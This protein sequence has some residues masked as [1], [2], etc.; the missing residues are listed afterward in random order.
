MNKL[1][2]FNF[3]LKPFIIILIIS[4]LYLNGSYKAVILILILFL[5]DC[6][7][8]LSKYWDKD[9]DENH[10]TNSINKCI[11]EELYNLI[12]PTV[13]IKKDGEI[14]WCN[15]RF[16]SITKDEDLIKRN[17]MSVI[18]GINIDSIINSEKIYVHQKL[19]LGKRV[20]DVQGMKVL[21]NEDEYIILFFNDISDLLTSDGIR[22]EVVLIEVD[23]FTDVLEATDE[24]DRPLVVAEIERTINAYAHN[25]NAM[26]RKYDNNKYVLSVQN[27][28]IAEQEREKFPIL[29]E[30]S[31]IKKGNK[32]E[33]TIS[34]GIGRDGL[35]PLENNNFANMALELA[36]GR[37]GDQVV[38]KNNEKIKF[39]GGNS[40]E[41]EKRTR[42]RA[43]VV[44]NALNELI[45]DSSKVY[46]MGHTN[47]DM[48]CFGSALALSS[49]IR[50]MGKKSY[51]LLGSD[52]NPIEY[53]FDRLSEDSYYND[54][55]ISLDKA[56]D[57]LDDETLV[58]VVDVH[59]RGY[60]EDLGLIERAKNKVIIDH[61][62]RSPDIIT[63]SLLN[64]IEVYASSTSEMIT[65]LLQYMVKSPKLRKIEA[66]GLLSGIYMDTKGFSFK[67]G[68]R[69]FEA[70]SYLRNVGADTL[71]VK[72][73]FTDNLND[74]ILIADTIKSAKVDERKVAIAIC[75]KDVDTVIVAKAA[76]EL[77]NISGILVSFVVAEIDG[78]I[79]ISGRSSGDIN[80]QI[81][82]EALG[83][84][85]HMNIA[86]TKMIGITIEEAIYKL[87]EV[88][89]KYLKVGE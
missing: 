28:Y 89:E 18:N 39:Y 19:N 15:E 12:L 24:N 88:I 71:E 67:T 49:V 44:S 2:L 4:L 33:P 20:Y 46:I 79:C 85:G 59:N 27:R 54:R 58:I 57:E 53:F 40:N 38:L 78:A 17:I 80:V 84:G 74:F 51:I 60:V 42:V 72:K 22:E 62:R 69:T 61:H 48:D 55:F 16:L 26:I 3:Y 64:Y 41:I 86:G 35:T 32:L 45:Y 6:I 31:A 23:N 75:P 87:K 76:D 21:R 68:V 29:D 14:L 8:K 43:R 83:G 56:N 65:E 37:G 1:K 34:I 11:D 30:I 66:E 52:I 82:L 9:K 81:V 70:A 63:G 36:L 5:V 77:L 73:M 10:L 47:P 7:I 50:Q 13:L 25:I